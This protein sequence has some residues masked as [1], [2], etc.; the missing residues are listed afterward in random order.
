MRRKQP[1]KMEN[2]ILVAV[3]GCTGAGKSS[4]VQVVMGNKDVQIGHNLTSSTP[5][6]SSIDKE[7]LTFASDI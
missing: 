7:Y 5:S 4:F 3:M 1:A 2:P 6:E